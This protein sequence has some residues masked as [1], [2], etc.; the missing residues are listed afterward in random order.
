MIQQ[1]AE[2]A[3]SNGIYR[4]QNKN[5]L[6]HVPLDNDILEPLWP[7]IVNTVNYEMRN[8]NSTNLGWGHGL[9]II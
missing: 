9:N 1:I 7:I 3:V 2:G 4:C 6:R 8:S 5:K